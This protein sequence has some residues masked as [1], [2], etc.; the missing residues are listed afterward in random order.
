MKKR[1]CD[2]GDMRAQTTVPGVS[3]RSRKEIGK[4]CHAPELYF[5]LFGEKNDGYVHKITRADVLDAV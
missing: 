3:I 4:V 5:F 1:A 2:Q